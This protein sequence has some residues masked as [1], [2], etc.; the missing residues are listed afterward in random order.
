MKTMKERLARI[1]WKIVVCGIVAL[2]VLE[3]VALFNGINGTL[4]TIVVATI[5]A[6]VGVT[7]PNPLRKTI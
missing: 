6:V 5:G 3:C 1:D 4:F 2:T 7:I